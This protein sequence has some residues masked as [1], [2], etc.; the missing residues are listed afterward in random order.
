MRILNKKFKR[1]VAL[2]S[3]THALSDFGLCPDGLYNDETGK[4]ISA[5][6][7]KGQLQLLEYWNDFVKKCKYWGVDTIFHLGDAIQGCNPKNAGRYTLDPDMD[8]Q[9]TGIVKLLEPLVKGKDFHCVSGSLYHESVDNKVHKQICKD[10]Q[11]IAKNSEYHGAVYNG[12]IIGTGKIINAAHCSTGAAIY[13]STILDREA[14][15]VKVAEAEGRLEWNTTIIARGHLHCF[16][17]LDNGKTHMI[18]V[19]GW[20]TWYPL[21]DKVR[22]YGKMQPDIGGII[23]F[24]DEEG[25]TTLHHYLYPCPHI[26]DSLKKC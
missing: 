2:I 25:R 11:G 12:E 4:N 10:L 22:L 9:I 1:V 21:K 16:L 5:M 19:P 17:H 24:F 18:Q 3:D 23:L 8:T 14:L 13:R 7:S 6:R 20:Q 15:F 26:I